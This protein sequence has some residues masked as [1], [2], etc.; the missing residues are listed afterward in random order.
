MATNLIS[1]MAQFLSPEIVA[2]IASGLG[3]DK[4][5]TQKAAS[6]AVPGLLAALIS[7]VSKPQGAAKLNDAVAKQEAGVL[8]S[9]ASV[10]GQSGQKALIDNGASALSSLLGGKTV[11]GLSSALGQFAG[12]GESGS[13]NLMGLLGPAVLGV[14]GHQQ[15]SS[16]LDASG[17]AKLLNSQKDSVL[18]ALPSGFSKQLSGTDILDSLIGPTTRAVYQT[19]SK[20]TPSVGRWLLP[21]LALLAVGALAW[22]LLS[23]RH[24]EG[25]KVAIE[26]P[27]PADVLDKLRGAKV[28]DVDVG[29]LAKS[30]VF[31]LR[32]SLK[33]IKDEATAQAAVPALTQ[34]A[35]QF[36][37]LTGLLGQLTPDR[38]STRLNS[39]HETISRM[40]SSA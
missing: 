11:S 14:L 29:E 27:S 18:A 12:I 23:G 31:G 33:D 20:P 4:T 36:D 30:A 38:K 6:A 5:S 32:S 24:A 13:K 37:Q 1:E 10:I 22:Y 21:A 7:L 8:S 34:A 40:P 26:A 35:S 15:R 19:P 39:S 17:L 9:L 28:G 25:P 2:R 3:L 16:G